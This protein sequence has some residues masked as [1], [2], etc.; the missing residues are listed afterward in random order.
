MTRIFRP[1]CLHRIRHPSGLRPQHIA[2]PLRSSR[3]QNTRP[4]ADSSPA[5][6]RCEALDPEKILEWSP[7][8]PSDRHPLKRALVLGHPACGGVDGFQSH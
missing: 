5:A 6:V 8:D 1:H 4:C 2:R 7:S 3:L